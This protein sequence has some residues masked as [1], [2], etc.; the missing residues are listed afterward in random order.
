MGENNKKKSS[1]LALTWANAMKWL[2]ITAIGIYAIQQGVKSFP[3]Q[4]SSIPS[5]LISD[6]LPNIVFGIAASVSVFIVFALPRFEEIKEKV[7]N[8]VSKMVEVAANVQHGASVI[9]KVEELLKDLRNEQ[10]AFVGISRLLDEFVDLPESNKS[11]FLSKNLPQYARAWARLFRENKHDEFKKLFWELFCDIYFREEIK[12]FSK[13]IPSIST[14][15][16]LYASLLSASSQQLGD[17]ASKKGE[18]LH[19]WA[20]TPLMPE[21]WFNWPHIDGEYSNDFIENYRRE[22]ETVVKSKKHYF[23]RW[24]LLASDQEQFRNQKGVV[25]ANYDCFLEQRTLNIVF[26]EYDLRAD[27]FTPLDAGEYRR[28]AEH[29]I[30]LKGGVPNKAEI[31][32]YVICDTINLPDRIEKGPVLHK[33]LEAKLL[34]RYAETLHYPK[35]LARYCIVRPSDFDKLPFF[36][37]DWLAI[38]TCNSDHS[39]QTHHIPEWKII[40]TAKLNP[41]WDTMFLYL[42]T[43]EQH[44]KKF[45]AFRQFRR[46]ST[47]YIGE[48]AS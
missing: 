10:H 36:T 18:S 29:G 22:L 43:D 7:E 1:N 4:T 24:M 39:V 20:V 17:W 35:E 2:L 38:G 44:I 16:E 13:P 15:I 6:L 11:I 3:S 30:R 25:L 12:D 26:Y 5:W 47:R 9:V 41:S 37:T 34:D 45:E 33:L 14:N 27:I 28:L 21:N 19:F 48:A 23:E 31:K 32:K 40:I 8:L 42:I 46:L